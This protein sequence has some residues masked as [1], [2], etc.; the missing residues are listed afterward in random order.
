MVDAH[1][2]MCGAGIPGQTAA[3]ARVT[4]GAAASTSGLRDA[5]L[6]APIETMAPHGGKHPWTDAQWTRL[7]TS[8]LP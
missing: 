7:C 6:S 3:V 4:A 2:A 5:T 1:A 8:A